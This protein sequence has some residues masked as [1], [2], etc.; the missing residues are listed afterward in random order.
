MSS[1]LKI[2][3][4]VSLIM[5]ASVIGNKLKTFL[6]D[7]NAQSADYKLIRDFLVNDEALSSA[8][9][10]SL[11]LAGGQHKVPLWIHL[12]YEVNARVWQS[13]G[14]RNT[15]NLNQPY[16]HFTVK[17][18][19]AQCGR[20]MNVC[21]VD[22]YSFGWLLPSD[23]DAKDIVLQPEPYRSQLRTLLLIKLVHH[24]G[25]IVVPASFLCLKNLSELFGGHDSGAGSADNPSWLTLGPSSTTSSSGGPFV[26]EG[27]NRGGAAPMSAFSGASN[28][29]A[30]LDIAPDMRFFGCRKKKHPVMLD[31]VRAAESLLM[32]TSGHSSG[33]PQFLAYMSQWCLA[34]VRSRTMQVVAADKIGRITA[35]A[36]DA[37]KRPVTVD[38][39]FDGGSGDDGSSCR[40]LL[41]PDDQLLGICI[42]MDEILRRTKYQWFAS[43]GVDEILQ[44]DYLLARYFRVAAERALLLA[45]QDILVDST[46][47]VVVTDTSAI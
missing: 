41:L 31:M 24:Y 21:L 4:A 15:T 47:R 39:L 33:E 8:S 42:P 18:L 36:V 29:L 46:Q 16:I 32:P 30:G 40:P 27:A 22:D 2:A 5:F 38:D 45:Q 6:E 35:G 1:M 11:E 25:G 28:A 43:L 34:A 20:D 23:S 13:F 7:E 17:S 19:I 14:S 3:V 12:P 37:S 10:L 26:A 9:S 44:G